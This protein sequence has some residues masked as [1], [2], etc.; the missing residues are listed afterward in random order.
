[1][2]KILKISLG[3]VIVLTL[4]WAWLVQENLLPKAFAANMTL[5]VARGLPKTGQTVTAPTAN[6][7]TGDDGTYQKGWSGTRFTD[8]GD[9][10]ITDNAT[11]LMWVAG[12]TAA[13]IGSSYLWATAVSNCEDLTYAG[14]SD[15]RL[16]NIKELMSIVDYGD[17]TAPAIDQ[18]YFTECQ[19]D[20]YWSSTTYAPF[21]P[22]AWLVGFDD[23]YVDVDS[24]TIAPYYVRPVRGG[25]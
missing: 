15:W 8:N 13:G 16:P 25:Q 9:G 1:M 18:T 12:P 24:K 17:A 23:G 20:F 3:L 2:P 5:G 10:T 7:A 22:Y 11:G 21:A 6:Y 4:A 19:S 14:Y